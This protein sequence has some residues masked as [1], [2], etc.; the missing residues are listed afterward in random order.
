MLVLPIRRSRHKMRG[1]ASRAT[2][3]RSWLRISK[4][5]VL[6]LWQT[7]RQRF[8]MNV[9]PV[10]MVR[11]QGTGGATLWADRRKCRVRVNAYYVP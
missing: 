3:I 4:A 9:P 7:S 10:S 11:Q 8:Y 2:Q 6:A 1:R 5:S